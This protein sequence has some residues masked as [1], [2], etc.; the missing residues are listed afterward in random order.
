MALIKNLDAAT[1]AL[2]GVSFTREG[3][4]LMFLRRA[5]ILSS[6]SIL[7]S[8]RLL[9]QRMP[10]SVN[11]GS[12]KQGLKVGVCQI[13]VGADK[14]L[15]I[16]TARTA[17][18]EAARSGADLVVLPECW[19]SPYS[20]ACFPEYAE[21][22]PGAGET[23]HESESPS[24]RMVCDTAR[25]TGK[26]IVGG[27]IPERDL[28]T[29]TEKLFNTCLVINP[30]GEI[31]AKH[32]K[33]HLFDIDVPGK[34]TFKE[35]DSLSGG[36]S[37]TVVDTP[38]GGIGVGICY[39]I[40]FP[41]MALLQRQEKGCNMLVYPGAFNMVTGPAH[42]ELLQRARAVDNQ[43]FVITCSPARDTSPDPVYT[44]WGHSSV[45]NPWG[46]VIQKAGAEPTIIYADLD[47]KEVE[48]MRDSIPCWKQK[49]SDIYSVRV[50]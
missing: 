7:S 1:S 49:R 5:A 34:I 47:L 22:V 48:S 38:W 27:S 28:S 24:Y 45:V 6:L 50:H 25:E 36:H 4:F 10:I 43:V 20:T 12:V 33:V 39:D 30:E 13:D 16:A 14:K 2:C 26:W 8:S 11:S 3:S 21:K 41:E 17:L 9:P 40:R 42:W 31:V 44:A 32:R 46:E 23:P 29:G 37:L 15:N 18:E 35:S 19:N